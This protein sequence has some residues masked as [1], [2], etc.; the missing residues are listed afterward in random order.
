[1]RISE[2]GHVNV[3]HLYVYDIIGGGFIEWMRPTID[4]NPHLVI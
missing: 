2:S 1:M 4:E 3:V